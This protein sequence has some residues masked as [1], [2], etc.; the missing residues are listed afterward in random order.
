MIVK[1]SLQVDHSLIEEVQKELYFRGTINLN[2]PSGDFFYDPWVIKDIYQNSIWESILVTLGSNIGEARVIILKAGESYMAH[3][4]IDDRYHLNLKGEYSFLID[5][6]DQTMYPTVCN[7]HWYEMDAGKIHAATNYG[8]IDRAQIV[9]R[10]LLI[11]NKLEK[12]VHVSIEATDETQDYRYRFDNEISPWLNRMNKSGL[13]SNFK[14]K[15]KIVEVD[16]EQQL[17]PDL[18]KF[19]KNIFAITYE[20]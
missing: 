18:V 3:A 20:F 8:N 2:D 14:V 5:L 4:D 12:P 10:K 6:L 1:T 16:V 9:V 15:G 19:D 11:R 17:I 13:I 7:N